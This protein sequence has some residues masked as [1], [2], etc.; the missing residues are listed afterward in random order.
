MRNLRAPDALE[1]HVND[2]RL[3]S[4]AAR[5]L[6]Y[7]AMASYV[8][9]ADDDALFPHPRRCRNAALRH[10]PA[11]PVLCGEFR[12]GRPPVRDAATARRGRRALRFLAIRSGGPADE[13][14]STAR[15]DLAQ[16]RT[17]LPALGGLRG[18]PQGSYRAPGRRNF[19]TARA[20][21]SSPR[22]SRKGSPPIRN[23]P[24][25]PRS[26]LPA[27]FF[28]P[29]ARSMAAASIWRTG[30]AWCPLERPAGFAHAASAAIDRRRRS[31]RRA[32]TWRC[33]PPFVA[34]DF[35]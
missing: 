13:A 33:T 35:T 32:R 21:C 9:G 19:R 3:T 28:T 6:A 30:R 22:P 18:C 8:A 23:N 25:I 29:T 24:S 34:R 31:M 27:T 2:R 14:L 20:T 12:A 1:A 16:R 26:C 7:R 15:P 5:R 10:R 11:Q 17:W 4:A